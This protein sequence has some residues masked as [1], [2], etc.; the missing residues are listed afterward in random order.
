MGYGLSAY[1][2]DIEKLQAVF[3]SGD[4]SLR[5][6]VIVASENYADD[7][8]V[9]A[10]E[11]ENAP[12]FDKIM[13][14]IFQ[15]KISKSNN[16]LGHLYIHTFEAICDYLGEMMYADSF[17]KV[18]SE[19]MFAFDKFLFEIGIADHAHIYTLTEVN[20]CPLPLPT[21]EE[22]PGVNYLTYAQ[23][24]EVSEKLVNFEDETLLA[25]LI[26]E[27]QNS[28]PKMFSDYKSWF[29]HAAARKEGIVFFTY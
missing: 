3:G 18:R 12:D 16:D 2:V 29:E 28:N 20:N 23:I 19:E 14:E 13:T 7:V 9:M 6:A 10:E 22:F 25:Q 21:A 1:S 5:Q 17:S 15:G 24:V 8:N 26:A 27:T 11:E 4:D